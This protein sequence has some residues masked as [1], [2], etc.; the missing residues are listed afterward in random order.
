MGKSIQAMREERTAIAREIRNLHDNTTDWGQEAKDKFN[1]LEG[2]ITALDEEIDRYQKV[3]DLEAKNANV[4]DQTA[5]KLGTTLAT[6]EDILNAKKDVYDAWLRGGAKAA[7]ER[8]ETYAATLDGLEVATPADGGYTVPDQ[9]ASTLLEELAQIGGM[10]QAATVLATATGQ[11]ISFPTADETSQKGEMLGE[12]TQAAHS[13]PTFGTKALKVYKFSSKTV[14]V[15]IELLQDTTID[16]EGFIRRALV[17]RLSRITEDYYHDG[18]GSDQPQGLLTAA[19]QG[20][21]GASGQTATVIYEDLLD[22]IHA[23]DPAY[24]RG[25]SC[26]F[27]FNDTTLGGIRKLEDDYGRPLWQPNV[28]ESEPSRILGYPYW[29][30]Q[31]MADMAANAKSIVFGDLSKF[32]IRDAM[33]IQLRR[34]DDSRYAEYGMVGFLAMMRSGSALIAPSGSCVKY[35][36]NA[37]S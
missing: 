25:G 6:A 13:D 18:T 34:F 29:V 20:K 5:D 1:E 9:V 21:V 3:L 26:G 27:M 24:R 8:M 30:N 28:V 2:K 16:L 23:V 7:R 12:R 11:E 10:R 36:Q 15:S 19:T 33:D 32:I 4:V 31:E 22:L 35:Y 17:D 37:A 14:G